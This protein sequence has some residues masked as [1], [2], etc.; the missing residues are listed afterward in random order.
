MGRFAFG[1]PLPEF[2]VRT[3]IAIPVYNEEKHVAKVL[4]QV[5]AYM[6]APTN[7]DRSNVVVIDD[8]S[9][10]ATPMLLAHQ[11]VDVVRH[12]R[13]LGYGRSIREAFLW[14]EHYDFDWL[15]TMDCDE[16]HEPESLP[17]FYEAIARSNEAET[18]ADVISGSRYMCRERCGDPPPADRRKINAEVTGWVNDILNL[19]TPPG[20]GITDAFCGFK[21]YRVSRLSDL[22][23]N[24]DGYAIPLQMWVQHAAA[25]HAVR[26]VPIKLIYND[27]NRSFGG[28]LDNP[29]VRIG[30]Y[31]E[32]FEAELARY[33]ELAQRHAGARQAGVPGPDA[34]V[35]DAATT[36][37]AATGRG[38]ATVACAG[39]K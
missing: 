4:E 22:D 7:G 18:K 16:Q 17:A 39:G 30:H 2:R 35:T 25:G 9:S 1:R 20:E 10:D 23:L 5:A 27:P 36:A 15:I 37:D 32:V 21:A 14:A 24:V 19:T 3:L 33:P 28:P 31:R 26:E 34:A 13:N 12:Y 8:G 38:S 29:E 6:P 11:P